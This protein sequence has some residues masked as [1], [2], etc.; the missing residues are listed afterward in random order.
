MNLI[1]GSAAVFFLIYFVLNFKFRLYEKIYDC[2]KLSHKAALALTAAVCFV[3]SF[4]IFKYLKADNIIYPYEGSLFSMNAYEQMFDAFF[5]H[6]LNIDIIPDEM[7]SRLQ[8]PYDWGERN[9]YSF[10]YLWDRVY[11]NNTYY[12]YFGIAPVILI[13]FPFYFIT[14]K[15]PAAPTV[16]FILSVVA[17]TAI[18]FLVVKLHKIFLKEVNLALLI[19]SVL[20]V[21]TGSLIFM[22]QSSADS[23]YIAVSSGITFLALFLMFTFYA[24]DEEKVSKKCLYFALSGISLVFL[25]MSRPNLAL[26]F[27]IA[28]P[29]YISVIFS[30]D[31]KLSQ[32]HGQVISFAIPVIIGAAFVMWYNY[33]RFGSVF[34]FGAKYQLTVYDVSKY[35]FS[36]ALIMPAFYYYF[37]QSPEFTSEFPY[38]DIPFYRLTDINT[39]VYLTSTIGLLSFPSVWGA[40]CMPASLMSKK[41]DK[42]KKAVLIL[43][44]ICIIVMAVF[45]MCFAGVNIRY[46]SDIALIGVLF[47][48]VML[49]EFYDLFSQ[50]SKKIKFAVHCA[51]SVMLILSFA[52]GTFLIICNERNNL[53]NLA[54]INY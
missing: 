53:L 40:A 52:L 44:V 49:C 26:Y 43:S 35:A 51:M 5:K 47:T 38:L 19:F 36:T 30:K 13:Y 22:S 32:K 34:E 23:Y 25:V 29:I 48:S 10:A 16:C 6:Q 27:L 7:L 3:G 2:E 39:Y 17:I 21:E 4:V 45:D 42:T 33:A 31:F 24:Y 20:A 41:T 37:F 11:F 54:Q 1:I 28:V 12:S 9:L 15:V 14:G 8:N 50:G 46:L 18:L